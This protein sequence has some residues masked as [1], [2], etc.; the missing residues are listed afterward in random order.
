MAV[1]AV[2]LHLHQA[3]QIGIHLCDGVDYLGALFLEVLQVFGAAVAALG[4]VRIRLI[5]AQHI[6]GPPPRWSG[7]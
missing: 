4:A 1:K 3:E 7:W 5:L 6:E 2:V